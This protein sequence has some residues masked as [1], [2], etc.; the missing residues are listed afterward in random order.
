MIARLVTALLFG[1]VG[2]AI[3]IS[4]GLWQMQRLHWKEAILAEIDARI[5]A[6][7]AALPAR[8][9][10]EADRYRPVTVTGRFTGEVLRVLVSLKEVGPGLRIIEAFETEA[11]RRILIDRG[12]LPEAD[13]TR[14]LTAGP[15]TVTGNLHWPDEV[16]RFTPP[17]DPAAGLWFA[18]D[19]G[20]MARALG[21]EATFLVAREPTGD[22]I[23]PIPVDSSG[24]PNDHWGYAVQWFSLAAVWLG[25]TAYLLWRI[26]RRT[27]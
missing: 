15:A 12:F 16:D 25:M 1:L 20:A 23:T 3:L 8:P 13:K 6:P 2:A 18:R 10:P 9:D 21:T 19:V 11:G 4:L 26:R 27:A 17:P 24:I 22:G 14:S 7:P 5:A